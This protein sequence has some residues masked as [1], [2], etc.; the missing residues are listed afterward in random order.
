M[1]HTAMRRS[2]HETQMRAV[3]RFL[4]L[5]GERGWPC[6]ALALPFTARR[7]PTRTFAPS[8][9]AVQVSGGTLPMAQRFFA[10]RGIT[11]LT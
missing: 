11:P 1:Q 7:R 6:D 3:Q 2:R 4:A 9:T 10:L 8:E 5:C